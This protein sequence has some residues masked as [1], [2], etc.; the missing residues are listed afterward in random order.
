M[1]IKQAELAD[2]EELL[3]LQRIAYKSEAELHDDFSIPP[4]TQT[5]EE[6]KDSFA[7]RTVLKIVSGEQILASGQVEL[8]GD[9]SFICRMA[10]WPESQGQGVGSKLMSAL[11]NVYPDTKRIELFTGEKSEANLAMYRRR[12]Y[13]EFNST[14]LGKTTVIFLEKWR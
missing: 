11:E 4:L 2:A 9:T 8:K 5:L 14:K 7:T 6:F 10:V 1:E 12:G 3:K 13:Q